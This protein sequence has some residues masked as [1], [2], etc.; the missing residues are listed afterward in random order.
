MNKFERGKDPKK[1]V[2]I[3]LKH[4]ANSIFK[5]MN[6]KSPNTWEIVEVTKPGFIE[7]WI[8]NTEISAGLIYIEEAK[9]KYP[10]QWDKYTYGST[11]Y[12]DYL[13]YYDNSR[14]SM[15]DINAASGLVTIEYWLGDKNFEI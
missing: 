10:D 2:G 15:F 3:G 5:R 12:S 14:A 8:H 9:K 6:Q 7:C 1:V 4:M 13:I 11:K